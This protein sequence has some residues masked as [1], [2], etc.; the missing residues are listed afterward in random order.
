[1]RATITVLNQHAIAVFGGTN[2][3][4]GYIFDVATNEVKPILGEPLDIEFRCF[5]ELHQVSE[6]AFVT[7][8]Q[9]DDDHVKKIQ[10]L[11][12][13]AGVFYEC[14]AIADYGRYY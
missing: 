1:M 5:S 3:N 14:R 12:N 13:R 11:R 10:I 8:G 4:N 7:V 6:Y 2:K 9:T